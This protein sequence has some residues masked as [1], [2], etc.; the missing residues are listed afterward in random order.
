MPNLTG[1]LFKSKNST[2]AQLSGRDL[3]VWAPEDQQA[4]YDAAGAEN[5]KKEISIF[6]SRGAK[7]INQ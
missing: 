7:Q 6:G 5:A 2:S 1:L 3:E 4:L